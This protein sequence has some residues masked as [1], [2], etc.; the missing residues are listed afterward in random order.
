MKSK[1]NEERR[2]QRYF[3]L[4][5]AANW[6]TFRVYPQKVSRTGRI[7]GNK[8]HYLSK[9]H[10][11]LMVVAEEEC[12]NQTGN[13]RG[14]QKYK[15]AHQ[16]EKRTF[17]ESSPLQWSPLGTAQVERVLTRIYKV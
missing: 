16:K 14:H 6:S 10:F 8:T 5:K 15:C 17:R 7:H 12:S 9:K 2:L 13:K 4:R 11:R 3:Q 1:V